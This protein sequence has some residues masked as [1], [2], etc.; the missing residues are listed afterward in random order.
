M[1]Y[2]QFWRN[3]ADWPR[4]TGTHVF[5]GH[6]LHL[7]GKAL[8]PYSWTGDEPIAKPVLLLPELWKAQRRDRLDAHGLLAAN[9]MYAV[10]PNDQQL[11]G[12]LNRGTPGPVIQDYNLT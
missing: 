7:F 4:D 9:P 6:A 11:P 1:K 12:S 8:Y 3:G 2:A 10:K 5:L